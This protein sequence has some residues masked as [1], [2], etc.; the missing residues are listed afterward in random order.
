MTGHLVKTNV[1]RG[2]SP[3]PRRKKGQQ[4]LQGRGGTRGELRSSSHG[5]RPS[6]D[7]NSAQK[8]RSLRPLRSSSSSPSP[9]PR[10]GS[11]DQFLASLRDLLH[12]T[13]AYALGESRLVYFCGKCTTSRSSSSGW[14]LQICCPN[15]DCSMPFL[16]TFFAPLSPVSRCCRLLSLP[17][18]RDWTNKVL[19]GCKCILVVL[20]ILLCLMED[21]N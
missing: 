21:L 4:H 9:S 12:V 15:L 6:L 8:S 17:C 2:G 11:C 3:T 5:S 10:Y 19:N 13:S 20:C 14:M 7:F 1:V 18:L 16:P